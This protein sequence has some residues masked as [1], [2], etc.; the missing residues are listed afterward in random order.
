MGQRGHSTRTR[1]SA[2]RNPNG[3]R[4]RKKQPSRRTS[5]APLVAFLLLVGLVVVVGGAALLFLK[6]WLGPAPDY[7]GAGS[8][9]AVVEVRTGDTASDIGA[10]LYT[11]DVVKSAGAFVNAAEDDS[12]SRGL[13]PGY[14]RLREHMKAALALELMLEPD[15]VIESRVTIPEGKRRSEILPLV[16]EHTEL[17]AKQLRAAARDTEALGL[18][19]YAGGRLEGFLFPATYDVPPGMGATELLRTMVARY[20]RAAEQV[21]L[22]ARAERAGITPREAITIASLVQAEARHDD[23]FGKVARVVYNRLDVGMKLQFD[24]TVN[25]A[26]GGSDIKLSQDDIEHDSPYNTYLHEGLPPRPIGSPGEQALEA[27]L[28]PPKGDWLYFVTVDPKGGETK[29]TASYEEFQRFK[30]EFEANLG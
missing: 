9:R 24:S 3:A 1:G 10:A 25:Y 23:D 28:S 2:R 11:A 4:R 19:G 8:G 7:Q 6:G 5:A 29:F 14:Y 26:Q 30:N 21:D 20:Q 13:Q 22:V 27:T 15:S 12:R 17:S 18:P 16:A